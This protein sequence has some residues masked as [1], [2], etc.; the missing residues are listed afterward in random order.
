LSPEVWESL[1]PEAKALLAWQQAQIAY[2][3]AKQERTE[4]M[5]VRLTA[6]LAE[7]KE[8]YGRS[9]KNSSKPPSS[10]RPDQ[11]PAKKRRK[12]GAR[13]PG[14]QRGRKGVT[15]DLIPVEDVKEVVAVTP[16]SCGECGADVS[17]DTLPYP[18]RHQVIE[19]PPVV[20]EVTEFLRFSAECDKCGAVTKAVLP[21]GVPR[22]RFGPRLMAMVVLLTGLFRMSKRMAREAMSSLFGIEMSVGS[23]PAIERRVSEALSAPVD[24]AARHVQEQDAANMD[25]TG[26]REKG[27]RAWLWVV[28]TARVMVFRI[29]FSRATAVAKE[30]LGDCFTGVLTSDRWG[31]YNWVSQERR[32]LCWAHLIRDFVAIAERKGE[33]RRIGKALLKAVRP[34]FRM[35]RKVRD[36]TLGRREFARRME[37]VEKEV[38]GLLAEGKI[39][40]HAKTRGTCTNLDKVKEAMWTFVRHEGIEPTNNVAERAVRHGVIWRK[41]CFGTASAAGSRYVERILTVVGTLRA[42]GR[43]VLDYLVEAVEAHLG[44]RRAPSLLPATGDED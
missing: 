41:L 18:E 29:R 10:D 20:P 12:K 27:K 38:A 25:E 32:Q 39:C 2:L 42:Q 11:K 21:D 22:G 1:P 4:A 5:L 26:W 40:G 19:I 35:W 14:G 23:V 37:P 28:V 44:S 6:E 9:S 30:I 24:E 13:K 3:T 15:R 17:G 31:A 8:K 7:L 36:G 16:D 34:A 33:A 43:G